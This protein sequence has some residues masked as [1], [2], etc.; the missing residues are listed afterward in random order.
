MRSKSLLKTG[1]ALVLVLGLSACA[2]L[3]PLTETDIQARIDSDRSALFTNQEPVAGSISLAEATAR[4]LKYNLDHKLKVMETA[5]AQG[6][7]DIV[8]WDMLPRVA[9]NAGYTARSN[10][11][12]ASSKSLIS[13]SQSLESST[14][15]EKAFETANLSVAWNV[16]DFGVTYL[17]SKQQADRKLIAEERK[18]KVVHNIVQDVRYAWWRALSAQRLLPKVDNLQKQTQAALADSR[19]AVGRQLASPAQALDYQMTLLETLR[20]VGQLKRDLELAK[21]ELAALMNLAPGTSYG[22][23]DPGDKGF[24]VPE[25]PGNL[26]DIQQTALMNRPE[27]REEDYNQRISATE[28]NKAL[29]RLLPGLEASSDLQYSGNSFLYHQSWI[30]GGLKLTWNLM[31][32][33]SAYPN[34]KLNEARE[35][36]VKSKRQALG[37]AVLTQV[38]VSWMRY[39]M[40][41]EDFNLAREMNDVAGKLRVQSEAAQKAQGESGLEAIRRSSKAMFVELQ[42]DVAFAELQNAAGRMYA[43]AGLDPLPEKLSANDLPTVTAEVEKMLA[44]WERGQLASKSEAAKVAIAE[45]AKVEDAKT[46]PAKST[47]PLGGQAAY[48]FD[49]MAGWIGLK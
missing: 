13:G 20:Q 18:R 6:E 44:G 24:V 10:E 36:L 42:R 21:A 16:L 15:T 9:A 47:A 35:D 43:S 26:S 30:E 38:N 29:L 1:T 32:L 2:G 14:S 39:R 17:R 27:L 49:D 37:M 34:Y 28:T 45:P 48:S 3:N 7:A 8:G 46:V 40:A 31:S 22:L 25:P 12:G 11:A 19:A 5:L 41:L 33:A 23:A 4:A